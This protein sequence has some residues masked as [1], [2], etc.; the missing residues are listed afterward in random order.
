MKQLLRW[1]MLMSLIGFVALGIDVSMVVQAEDANFAVT[2]QDI[3][4]Q[5]EA[6]GSVSFVDTFTYDVKRLNEVTFD[7]NHEGNAI[8]NYRVGVRLEEEGEISY[9]SENYSASPNSFSAE[10]MTFGTRFRAY[11]PTED[12][13][14]QFVFEYTLDSLVTNYTDTA[15]LKH[16]LANNQIDTTHD[17]SAKILLPGIANNQDHFQAWLH[18]AGQSDVFLSVENNR[19][20]IH[21]TVKNHP[22]NQAIETNV[23]FPASLTPNNLNRI[24]E[25]MR[26][27]IIEAEETLADAELQAFVKKRNRQLM[28]LLGSIVFGPLSVLAAYGYYFRSREKLNP[29]RKI[30]PDT[31]ANLPE[32]GITPAIMATSI[33][34]SKPNADDFTA[35]LLD[36]ARKGFIE[37]TEVRK[38]RRGVFGDG[39]SSTIKISMDQEYAKGLSG[40]TPLLQHERQVINYILTGIQAEAQANKQEFT[41]QLLADD[42]QQEQVVNWVTLEQMEERSKNDKEFRKLQQNNWKKFSDYAELNGSK[43]RG[44]RLPEASAAHMANIAAI[45]ISLVMGILGIFVGAEVKAVGLITLA[46]IIFSVS[47]V[48]SVYLLVIRKKRPIVTAEQD[49]RNQEWQAFSN[50]LMTEKNQTTRDQVDLTTWQEYLVYA[51][52]LRAADDVL[53]YINDAFSQTDIQSLNLDSQLLTHPHLIT[54]VLRQS[55]SKTLSVIDP[56]SNT[57]NYANDSREQTS[58]DF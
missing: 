48:A 5:V 58:D 6:S 39:E 49:Q 28:L 34:R 35:T 41:Q 31:Q 47:F 50:M 42:T 10:Q 27:E 32:P 38:E 7:L 26:A 55:I 16:Q 14:L 53:D 17:F 29:H 20:V 13:R 40:T 33:Y 37:M 19:S 8:R 46:V 15:N 9:L 30:L 36:L 54:G 22:A 3:V 2:Q 23:I 12:A 1:L 24:E 18:T 44:R 11:L 56:A 4:A 45:F 51:M 43:R 52:S 25:N 21:L 57:N